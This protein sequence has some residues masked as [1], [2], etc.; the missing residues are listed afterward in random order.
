[1]SRFILGIGDLGATGDPGDS[2]IT[3]AL[4][5][6][7]AVVA[8]CRHTGAFG[9]IHVALP[10]STG[11]SHSNLPAYYADIGVPS[12]IRSMAAV[13]AHT[14]EGLEITLVGGAS[15]L[16]GLDSFGIG[17]RNVLAARKHLWQYGLAPT[18]ED[19]GGDISRS[20]HVTVGRPEV[21]ITNPIRG[22]WMLQESA[23][24][25]S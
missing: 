5:S 8:R 7:V 15:V 1:M 17:K 20:V 23:C 2:L 4:G 14:R 3:H 18:A 11:G 13:G 12:L 22:T 24:R 6:C 19:V 10:S 9:M 16:D 21:R 25:A